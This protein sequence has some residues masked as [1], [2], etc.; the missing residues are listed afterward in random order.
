MGRQYV[1]ELELVLEFFIFSFCL[2]RVSDTGCLSGARAYGQ[3]EHLDK[4]I[5]ENMQQFAREYKEF[6]YAGM[7]VGTISSKTFSAPI[8]SSKFLFNVNMNSGTKG[9]VLYKVG[10]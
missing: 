3:Y 5:D 9:L 2:S 10:F 7:V 4:S 8:G 1:N 6:S